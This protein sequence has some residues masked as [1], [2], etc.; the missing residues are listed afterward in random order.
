[1]SATMNGM[2]LVKADILQPGQLVTG[3]LILVDGEIVEVTS[4]DDHENGNDYYVEYQND[5]GE[6]DTIVVGYDDFLELYIYID[7]EE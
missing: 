6:M 4:V 1:M 5:F 3:D 7:E 2:E